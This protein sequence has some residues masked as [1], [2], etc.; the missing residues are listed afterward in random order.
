MV[1]TAADVRGHGRPATTL[2][3]P[4]PFALLLLALSACAAPAAPATSP[5]FVVHALRLLP[6]QDLREELQRYVDAHGIEAGCVL[7]CAGSLTDWCLRFADQPDGARGQGHFEIVALSGTLSSHGSHLH[8]AIADEQGR[9]IGGHLLAGCRVYTTAEVV[10]GES[11]RHVFTRERDGTTPW[12]EL[13]IR[14]VGGGT[15]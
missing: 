8:L 2:A 1:N 9:T 5:D 15:R 11:R 3:M 10:L 12:E 6:G 14:S 7:S 13:Q 4:R